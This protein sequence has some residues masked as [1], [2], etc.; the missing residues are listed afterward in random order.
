MVRHSRSIKRRLF[1]PIIRRSVSMKNGQSTILDTLRNNH[2]RIMR[3]SIL[4]Y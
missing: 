1:L 3:L 4:S 2:D